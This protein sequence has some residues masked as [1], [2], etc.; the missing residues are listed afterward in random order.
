MPRSRS[1]QA[2]APQEPAEAPERAQDARPVEYASDAPQRSPEAVQ[3]A[4]AHEKVGYGAHYEAAQ[5]APSGRPLAHNVGE[6]RVLT[7]TWAK[8][9]GRTG[10]TAISY[11]P[12]TPLTDLPEWAAKDVLENEK[13]HAEAP[14]AE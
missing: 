7:D 12:G 8:F 5:N 2:D 11:G 1:E 10:A 6:G 9:D 3:A 13:L 14:K 4:L